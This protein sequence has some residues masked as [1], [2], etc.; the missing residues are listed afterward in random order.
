[1]LVEKRSGDGVEMG[2]ARLE[3][4]CTE[5]MAIA[6]QAA[7]SCVN[8]AGPGPA[9]SPQRSLARGTQVQS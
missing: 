1:M 2:S 7:W 8:S 6:R 9:C 4:L 3:E 5:L